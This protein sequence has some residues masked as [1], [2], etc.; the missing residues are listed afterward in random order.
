MLLSLR[1]TN[2]IDYQS[3]HQE[4]KEFWKS[5]RWIVISTLSFFMIILSVLM[6]PIW[7]L[8]AL[9]IEGALWPT[10]VRRLLLC[11]HISDNLSEYIKPLPPEETR[12]NKAMR[13]LVVFS[14]ITVLEHK[15]YALADDVPEIKAML[16][17]MMWA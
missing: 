14:R 5:P 1:P 17:A 8:L 13:C 10:R 6:L 2:R 15:V 7:F 11:P 12:V 3:R 9:V 16:S 4:I